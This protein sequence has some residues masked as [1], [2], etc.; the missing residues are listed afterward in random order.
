MTNSR[1]F[2]LENFINI[3]NPDIMSL[4]EVKLNQER[5]NFYLRLDNYITYY[6]PRKKNPDQ[7]GVWQY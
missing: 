7:G 3:F 2:E 5:G 6:R 1:L 4:Q